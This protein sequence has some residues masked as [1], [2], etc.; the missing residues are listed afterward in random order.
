MHA[1]RREHDGVVVRTLG[2]AQA[3]VDVAADVL[4]VDVR[5]QPANLD[6]APPRGR[7]DYRL[8]RQCLQR[9]AVPGHQHVP[10]IV[11]QRKGDDRRQR[12]N[13]RRQILRRVHRGVDLAPQER[14]LELTRE[15]TSP[16]DL[17]QRRGSIGVTRRAN[18]VDVDRN[19]GVNGL[20]PLDRQS[21]LRQRQLAASGAESNRPPGVRRMVAHR[22]DAGERYGERHAAFG[23]ES[24]MSAANC[25]IFITNL[26]KSF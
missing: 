9:H 12:V 23:R 18:D 24:G 15:D 22:S 10:R 19:L 16:T 2:F 1:G 21:S 26:G 7:A 17:T 11:P 20:E 14:F 5:P 25:R 8:V 13:A 4:D 3:G 6:V